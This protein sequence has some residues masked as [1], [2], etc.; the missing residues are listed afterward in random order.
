M[1][2]YSDQPYNPDDSIMDDSKLR[3]HRV[4]DVPATLALFHFFKWVNHRTRSAL[5]SVNSCAWGL[6]SPFSALELPFTAQRLLRCGG[7]DD[8]ASCLAEQ[9]QLRRMCPAIARLPVRT[10]DYF[11]MPVLQLLDEDANVAAAI[12]N[13]GCL[14]EQRNKCAADSSL[15]AAAGAVLHA[16]TCC[17][18]LAR[19][20]GGW[21]KY[22]YVQEALVCG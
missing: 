19:Q 4:S 16:S 11:L 10:I 20:H 21:A 1:W 9:E 2:H 14:M 6:C 7:S 15:L 3:R 18:N 8:G 12:V 13:T 17:A 5:S 22:L